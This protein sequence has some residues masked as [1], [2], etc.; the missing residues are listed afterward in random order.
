MHQGYGAPI[1]TRIKRGIL[2]DFDPEDIDEAECREEIEQRLF[3]LT[4][5]PIRQPAPRRF[6]S[7][8]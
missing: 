5:M 2:I 8:L 6:E 4:A 3:N 7:C 1:V